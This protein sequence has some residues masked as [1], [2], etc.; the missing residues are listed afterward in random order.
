M[1]V[2]ETEDPDPETRAEIMVSL[3]DDFPLG[4]DEE[5]VVTDGT[6][7]GFD[8]LPDR[9]RNRIPIPLVFL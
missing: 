8:V 7:G 2:D 6:G 4:V 3:G 9:P 1:R 5:T